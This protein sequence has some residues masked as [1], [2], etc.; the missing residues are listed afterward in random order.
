MQKKIVGSNTPKLGVKTCEILD[1]IK[2]DK[3]VCVTLSTNKRK[4]QKKKIF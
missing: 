4:F 3:V 2:N 1:L